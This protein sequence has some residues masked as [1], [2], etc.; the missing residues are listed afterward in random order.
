MFQRRFAPGAERMTESRF[1]F[2]L[3]PGLFL[4]HASIASGAH[5]EHYQRSSFSA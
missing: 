2:R 1:V 4:P 5:A 3:T